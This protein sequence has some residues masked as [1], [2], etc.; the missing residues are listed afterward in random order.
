MRKVAT[1]LLASVL[2]LGCAPTGASVEWQSKETARFVV[3]YPKGHDAAAGNVLQVLEENY[4]RIVENLQPAHHKPYSVRL[5]PDLKQ[6]HRSINQP[7]S[8]SWVVGTAWGDSEIRMVSPR[9]PGPVHSY[10]S[11]IQVAVH[12]FTHCV[13]MRLAGGKSNPQ[14]YIW[15]WESIALYEAGQFRNPSSIAYMRDG[16]YPKFLDVRNQ[17]QNPEIYDMGYTVMEYLVE[18]FGYETVRQLVQKGGSVQAALGLTDAE[19]YSEWYA[20]VRGKYLSP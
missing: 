5:Y 16:S 2:L 19:F 20:F 10:S 9:N 12:E 13:T 11:L 6:F 4:E 8:P 7:S 15:L 18:T 1:I 3:H 17:V 14:S